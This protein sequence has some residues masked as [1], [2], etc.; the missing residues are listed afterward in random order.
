[1][2]GDSGERRPYRVQFPD[3]FILLQPHPPRP[4]QHLLPLLLLL[5]L[6]QVTLTVPLVLQFCLSLLLELGIFQSFLRGQRALPNPRARRG[7]TS[8]ATFLA[9]SGDMTGSWGSGTAM[10]TPSHISGQ[11]LGALGR[12]EVLGTIPGMLPS[13]Q[14]SPEPCSLPCAPKHEGQKGLPW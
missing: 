5:L 3:L 9:L 2:P 11:T 14:W 8:G 1:M 4:L 12:L 6:L 7:H 13:S 10:D